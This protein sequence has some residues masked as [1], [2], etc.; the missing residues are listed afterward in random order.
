MIQKQKVWILVMLLIL[1]QIIPLTSAIGV[2]PGRTILEFS[3]GLEQTIPLTIVN[4]KESAIDAVLYPEGEL[5]QYIEVIPENIQFAAGEREKQVT[6]SIKLPTTIGDPGM[7]KGR[8][9][10]RELG[11]TQTKEDTITIGALAAVASAVDVR[12]PYPGKFVQTD[13]FVPETKA[14]EAVKFLL[15]TR[16]LGTDDIKNAKATIHIEDN[17]GNE[18][19]MVETETKSINAGQ[20]IELLTSWAPDIAYGRY[21]AKIIMEYDGEEQWY[22]RGFQIGEFMLE[23][24]AVS[25]N[26]FRLGDVAKLNILVKSRVDRTIPSVVAEMLLDNRKGENVATITSA[27]EEVLGGKMKE[28]LAYWDTEEVAQGTYEGKL[29]LQAENVSA[30]QRVRT[31]VTENTFVTEFVDITGRTISETKVTLNPVLV[32]KQG[33]FILIVLIIVVGNII[34]WTIYRKKRKNKGNMMDGF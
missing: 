5:A 13:L 17:A 22:E 30:E 27:G 3:P 25:V 2:T 9:I 7:H 24:I 33:M 29:I 4:T 6:Y 15:Q 10:A 23:P 26:N 31:T 19:A 28:L 12:V 34:G 20:R 1:L 21:K 16:N 32:G 14:N 18:I 11:S 8:I